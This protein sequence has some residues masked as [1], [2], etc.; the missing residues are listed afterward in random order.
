MKILSLPLLALAAA[1]AIAPAAKADSF[2]F[3]YTAPGGVS[4]SGILVGTDLGYNVS[5]A[6]DE[7]LISS[8]TGGTFDDGVNSGP[9]S[10]VQNPDT[11]NGSPQSDPY[12]LFTYDDLLYPYG[13]GGQNL[14][15]NGLFFNFDG[16]ELNLWEGGFP[17]TEGWYEYDPVTTNSNSGSGI[18]YITPEPGTLLL[19]STGLFCLAGLLLR[20]RA[21][22]AL[23]MNA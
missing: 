19:L 4:G 16:M 21:A 12:S 5:L 20:R 8:V 15:Y 22:S 7:W 23:V 14:D 17:Y 13:A 3:I 1:L 9:I 2:G 10:L 11:I 18:F 6:S